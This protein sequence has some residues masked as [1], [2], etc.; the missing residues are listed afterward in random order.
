MNAGKLIINLDVLFF[1]D[2][3][4]TFV[5]LWA[6]AK[7]SG[8]K[9]HLWRI[10]GSALIGSFYTVILVLPW[11]DGLTG[12]IHIICHLILNLAVATLMIKIAFGSLKVN[13]FIKVLGYFYLITFLAGGA[14]FSIYFIIG[15]SP[16]QWI[17]GWMNLGNSY[18]WLYFVA[19]I[20]V[21]FI[22]RY[23]WNWIREK[24][25]RQEYHLKFT[26]CINDKSVELLGLVDTGN[27]LKEPMT[28]R[29]VIVVE[30]KELNELFSPEVLK[31]LSDEKEDV[32]EQL[33]KLLETPWYS[34][35]R[36]IPFS[37]LGKKS[38]LLVG[39]KPDHVEII[40]DEV[41][42]IKRVIL[43]LYQGELDLM[44]EYQALL[45]PELLEAIVFE[46]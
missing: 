45:H 39:L 25:H 16:T 22:G 18:G 32:I 42:Q 33:E 17:L 14:A 10:V 26:V 3:L 11:F 21:I 9:I 4:M 6:T 28:N 44:G 19:I 12:I 7:F 40:G 27:L 34:R 15:S 43:A 5:L 38:G 20:L 29:P 23:G 31:I 2:F 1:N 35:F 36:I 8:I 13:K 41:H 37:S 24:L 30:M 46:N